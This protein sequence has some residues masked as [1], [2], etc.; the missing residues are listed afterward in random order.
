M[1]GINWP[2]GSNSYFSLFCYISGRKNIQRMKISAFEFWCLSIMR[3][4]FSARSQSIE[5]Y[6]WPVFCSI[7]ESDALSCH[8]ELPGL[9]KKDIL[10]DLYNEIMR[11]FEPRNKL[12]TWKLA[13]L[14]KS[15]SIRHKHQCAVN[16]L[17][18]D[19]ESEQVKITCFAFGRLTCTTCK[20]NVSVG[21]LTCTHS[22]PMTQK[23]AKGMGSRFLHFLIANFFMLSFNC[24]LLKW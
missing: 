13:V 23:K 19:T 7:F 8:D 17:G 4:F 9:R 3:A 24:F 10:A 11:L 2:I 14:P 20:L 15:S 18:S 22:L 5:T 6:C 12:K 21:V 16:Q 1:D